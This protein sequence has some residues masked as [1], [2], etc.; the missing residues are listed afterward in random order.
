MERLAIDGG[1]PVRDKFLPYATQWIGNEEKKEIIE[2]L[3]S[4]WITTGPKVS[5][6]EKDVAKYVGSK[7]AIAVNSGTAALHCCT[8]SIDLKTGDEVI[9]TPFTFLASANCIVYVGARPVLVDIKKDTYNIDPK[10]IKKKLTDKTKAIIPVHYGGQPCN[11]DEIYEI[12]R[13]CNLRVIE[14]AAHALSSEFKGK[15]IGGIGDLSTFSFHPVKNITTAEGGIITTNDEMLAR[16]CIM[17][18]THGITKEAMQ[19]YGK[20]TDW[21]YDMQRLGYRYNMTEFQA[22]LGIA[23]LKKIDKFQKRREGIIKIYNNN[24]SEMNEL[25]LPYVKPDV[26]SSWHLYTIRIK[27]KTIKVNRNQI[28]KALRKENIGVNVHYIPIHF[29]T[30]YQNNYGYKEGDFPKTEEI[31]KSIITLPLFPRMEEKD[32]FD[33]I[34]AVKKVIGYYSK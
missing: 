26:K 28:I 29:H 14:D 3:N 32:I 15:K 18:R 22:A 7:Y 6:F 16:L 21:Y 9:T 13:D 34:N 33:T 8:S 12:A 19:R 11:I 24:F 5:Q 30:Y 10:E 23:Q 31:Y 17:H 25:I 4:N 2:V 20:D 1:K 27:E